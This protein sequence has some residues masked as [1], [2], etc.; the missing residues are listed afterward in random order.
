M[1][2]RSPEAAPSRDGAALAR[3]HSA[4]LEAQNARLAVVAREHAALRRVATLVAREAEP[5][6]VLQAVS[7]E[8]CR[9]LGARSSLVCRYEEGDAVTVVGRWDEGGF[10][11]FPVGTTVPLVK[12]LALARVRHSGRPARNDGY[13]GLPGEA[14]RAIHA[15][16]F[17]SVVAAP[18]TVS[19][20]I[21]GALVVG[22]GRREGV[23]DDAEERLGEFAELVALALASAEARD[24]L[25]ASR[26]RLVESGDAERR[27]V[28]R[29]LHDGAQQRLVGLA[30]TLRMAMSRVRTD[31][32]VAEATLARAQAE[33]GGA[34]DELRELARGIHP[35]VL[36]DHGLGPALIAL[37]ERAPIP[38]EVIVDIPGRLSEG[39]ESAAYFVAAEALTNVAKYSLAD[40][41]TVRVEVR[42]SV[43]VVEIGDAGVGGADPGRGSGLRGLVDRVEAIR[44]RLEVTSPPGGG[45]RVRAELPIAG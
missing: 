24:Q 21:W 29:D 33:L 10:G 44:G 39:I 36:S 32:D 43:A 6:V 12:E 4:G 40:A 45:T 8:A 5:A 25:A 17:H 34:I 30:L 13:E 31:P 28:E 42:D 2:I 20:S 15:L 26:A 7:Q 16:G 3:L 1:A 22:A 27:R 14:A 41:A 19:S 9:V 11:G 35:A 18:I 23:P 38:V 37:A